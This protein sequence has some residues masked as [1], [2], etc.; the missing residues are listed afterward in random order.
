MAA[1]IMF[2]GARRRRGVYETISREGV[3]YV[4]LPLVFVMICS[5]VGVGRKRSLER[6]I[7]NDDL[8]AARLPRSSRGWG[9]WVSITHVMV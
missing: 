9:S 7:E 1:A 8:G 6:R 3:T 5:Q 4:V 2:A